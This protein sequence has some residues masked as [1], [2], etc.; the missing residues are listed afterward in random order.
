MSKAADKDA[1][2]AADKDVNKSADKELYPSRG[3]LI[4]HFLDGSKK[5][6]DDY[7]K[8]KNTD[9]YISGGIGTNEIP[10]RLFNRPSINLYRLRS[11]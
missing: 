6:F 3:S 1:N 10:L 8:V 9:I 11:H 7:Y 5:Y 4:L 2:K